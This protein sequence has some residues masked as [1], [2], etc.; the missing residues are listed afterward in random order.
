MLIVIDPAGRVRSLYDETLDL[1]ALGRP[2][3]ARGSYVEPDAQGRWMADLAPVSGPVLGPFAA[4]SQALDAERAW[5]EKHWLL[6][7]GTA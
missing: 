3:I 5:L 7:H 2:R 6:G 4:R 1:A